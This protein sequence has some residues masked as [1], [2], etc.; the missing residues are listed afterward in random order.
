MSE[1][2][3]IGINP[4]A[5]YF[6]ERIRSPNSIRRLFNLS[7]SVAYQWWRCEVC[8]HDYPSGLGLGLLPKRWHIDAG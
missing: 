5:Y 7:E 1:L 2:S 4:A 3:P 8:H 6:I